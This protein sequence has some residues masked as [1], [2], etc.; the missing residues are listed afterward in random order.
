MKKLTVITTAIAI[1]FAAPASAFV[2]FPAPTGPSFTMPQEW[3]EGDQLL[4]L[5]GFWQNTRPGGNC[6]RLAQR[7]GISIAE[8]LEMGREYQR[9]R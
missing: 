6:D 8:A 7:E 3:R 5:C 1:A 9:S 4:A 2:S